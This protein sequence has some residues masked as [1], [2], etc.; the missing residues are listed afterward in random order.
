MYD[1]QS[2][3]VASNVYE[4]TSLGSIA[5]VEVGHVILLVPALYVPLP[6]TLVMFV[7]SVGNSSEIATS[8]A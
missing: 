4:I 6:E 2:L 5:L 8:N 7:N 1:A 3:T